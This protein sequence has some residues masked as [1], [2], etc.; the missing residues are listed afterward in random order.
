MF[1]KLSGENKS[2]SVNL[3]RE[4][5]LLSEKSMAI[6]LQKKEDND[7]FEFLERLIDFIISKNPLS[8]EYFTYPYFSFITCLSCKSTVGEAISHEKNIV[9]PIPEQDDSITLESLLYAKCFCSLKEEDE[10]TLCSSGC[11]GKIHETSILGRTQKL[12][13]VCTARNTSSTVYCE[14]PVEVPYFMYLDS[15][16]GDSCGS[17]TYALIVIMEVVYQLAISIT[18]YS[19]EMVRLYYLPILRNVFTRRQMS[20]V[21]LKGKNTDIS[22]YIF[23]KKLFR[24]SSIRLIIPY[25]G[26]MILVTYKQLKIY[27]METLKYIEPLLKEICFKTG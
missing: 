19:I 26:R 3:S 22:L 25:H 11:S 1:K 9:L 4:F 27:T 5:S 20:Y 14:T 16:I 23:M 12:F 24:L 21:M 17:V 8:D 10:R 15:F 7:A 13:A 2:N 18:F 6:D